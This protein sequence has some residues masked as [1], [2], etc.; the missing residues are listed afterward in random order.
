VT[1]A[2]QAVEASG[3]KF[4]YRGTSSDALDALELSIEEG[5]FTVIMGKSG[6]GKST[7]CYCLNGLIP[8]FLRG[9]MQGHVRVF[10]LDTRDHRVSRLARIVG[11]VFQDFEAQLF[12]T[13]VELEVAFGPENF[14]LPL[15]EIRQRVR[16]SLR[17]VKL[18]GYERRQPAYLSGGQKQR[19][20]IASI[21]A[22]RP[23]LLVMD[24]PT[25]D[26]DPIGKME[27]FEVADQLRQ[28]SD[29]TVVIVEHETEEALKAD[30]V[31]LMLNGKVIATGRPEQILTNVPLLE[32]SGVMPPQ[33]SHLF[34]LLGSSLRPL[35]LEDALS[36]IWTE[37]LSIDEEKYRAISGSRLDGYGPPLIEVEDLQFWYPG[38]VPAIKGVS[39]QIRQGEFV[40][41]LGQNG[42][43]KTTLVKHFNGLL[44]P[45]RG[46]VI[47][48]GFDTRNTSVYQLGR[49]V[50][51]VFQNPDHQI[52]AQT[53]FD[54]V[55][56]GPRLYGLSADE[57]NRRVA[58]ALEAVDL[59]HR[60][61]ADPFLLTKGER[62]RVAVASVL[63]AKPEVI[64][65][66][67]PTTGLDYLELKSMMELIVTHS[68]WV[69]AQYAHRII[70]MNNGKVIADGP[71]REVF[72][73]EDVLA[74][75]SLKPPPIV[76]L[77]NR[78]GRPLLSVD[79]ASQVLVR[80]GSLG[81]I[82][83]S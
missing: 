57:V 28:T 73:R 16:E 34:H 65:L 59:S 58:E 22:I 72:A 33:T 63:A 19:L 46:T 66:D 12:S 35:T 4:R 53:V 71:T 10:G 3:L 36:A 25:T 43:G 45:S 15:E 38:G 44:K 47:V 83:L 8:H 74:E 79:E 39:L 76:R 48:K 14:A 11:L 7:F 80:S 60:R 18:E 49:L 2:R 42:S 40:A 77:G 68:M 21:L 67:E 81:H 23:R 37:G 61:G 32:T 54:E 51:Y 64:V 70:V 78:L 50:G 41:I 1:S 31:V 27:V 6:A 56:F 26:L 17:A 82:P 24:E 75:A 30:Q 69:A 20:A 62:Q 13:N 5:Q 29:S 9:Q 55:A 52:F